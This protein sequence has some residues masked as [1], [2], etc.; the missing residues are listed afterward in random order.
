VSPRGLARILATSGTGLRGETQRW[1]AEFAW[2]VLDAVDEAGA[3]AVG[4]SGG[5]DYG[6]AVQ[7]LA[8]HHGDLPAGQVGAE[9][10][11]P[12][13]AAEAD[14]RVRRP[15]D[16]E[17]VSVRE[18]RLV[19]GGRPL[20]QHGL[21]ALAVLVP[22]HHHVAGHRPAHPDHRETYRTISS[23]ARPIRS[24]KSASSSAR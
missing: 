22:V 3:Q 11:V 15:G 24:S 1:S 16:V 19:S 14:V 17:A 5:A 21:V 13:C 6:Y 7:Q 10:E 8:Q 2:Q 18:D 23:T 4:L 12:S 9:A 20:E